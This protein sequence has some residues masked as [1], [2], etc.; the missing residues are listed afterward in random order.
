MLYNIFMFKKNKLWIEI[1]VISVFVI[2]FFLTRL[3]PLINE[4]VPYTY[5]QGRD[6]LKAAEEVKNMRPTFIGPTTGIIGIFHGAWWYYVLIVPYVLTSGNPMGFYYFI[7]FVQF[8]CFLVL[9][10]FLKRY[11][12]DSVRYLA[13]LIVTTGGYFIGTSVFAGNNVMVLPAMLGFLV[14]SFYLLEDK[15]KKY[16]LVLFLVGLFLGF[17]AEFEFAFGLMIVPVYLVLSITIKKLRENIYSIKN[18]P[19]FL[20]G[21]IIPF[22]PRLLFEVKHGFSQ[23]KLLIGFFFQPKFYNPKPYI[24]I[25][26][27][28]SELFLG[29]TNGVFNDKLSW[30]LF[31]IIF[32]SFVFI[33]RNKKF[34]YKEFAK[35]IFLLT[36]LLFVFST[37]Y[38]DNFW[39]NYYEGIHYLFLFI[40]ILGLNFIVQKKKE[41]KFLIYILMASVLIKFTPNFHPLAKPQKPDGLMIQKAVVKYIV[42]KEKGNKY[43]VKIYTPPVIPHT[44]N[45]L[46]DYYATTKKTIY[47]FDQYYGGKCW[48]I[49]ERDPYAFRREKWIQ[50]NFFKKGKLL[51]HTKIYGEVDIYQ[52]QEIR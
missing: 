24:D 14:S 8:A 16:S 2:I 4:T 26:K 41:A 11:F 37:F 1:I 39:G 36:I 13:L 48:F 19:Y 7:L 27:D 5:D 18:F 31:I 23:T 38:K 46:F 45:Y 52:Y 33:V 21:L 49:V 25:L 12:E 32:I 44:Y 17:I 6:F 42:D 30:I 9:N 10:C 22:L 29:Y 51:D 43:C 28:R 35:F 20:G 15:T 47:P 40:F 34:I 3:G 50:D